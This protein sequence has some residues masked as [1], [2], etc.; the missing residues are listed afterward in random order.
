MSP[1]TSPLSG[2]SRSRLVLV[3]ALLFAGQ[4]GFVLLLGERPRPS[5]LAPAPRVVLRMLDAPLDDENLTKHIF[6]EDPAVFPSTSPHGFAAQAWRL[7][8]AHDHNAAALRQPMPAFL[9]F[10]NWSGA[11]R[12]PAVAESRQIPFQW[13]SRPNPPEDTVT[14]FPEAEAS[15][16]ESFLLIEGSLQGRRWPAPVELHPWTNSLLSNSVVQFAVNRA[17]Q[18]VSAVLLSGSGLKEADDSALTN[19]N[20]LRFRPSGTAAPAF[21]WGTATFYWKSVAPPPPQKPPTTNTLNNPTA[22]PSV[23]N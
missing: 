11:E 20:V 4:A 12:I 5:P 6:A 13:T 19:V 3:A 7:L 23:P 16:P 1:S 22:A 9:D 17:G 10:T 15:R 18:V 14:I 8:P 2:W 21:E